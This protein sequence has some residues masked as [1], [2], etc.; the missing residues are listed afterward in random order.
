MSVSERV[1]RTSVAIS[2]KDYVKINLVRSSKLKLKLAL[3]RMI[4]YVADAYKLYQNYLKAASEKSLLTVPENKIK[5]MTT[6]RMSNF[7]TTVG[8]PRSRELTDEIVNDPKVTDTYQAAAAFLFKFL[9]AHQNEIASVVNIGSG[10]DNTLQYLSSKFRDIQFY[11]NDLMEDLEDI[12]RNYLQNYKPKQNWKFIRGYQLDLIKKGELSGDL[13]FFK[14]TSVA[15]IP[16]EFD[17][18]LSAL[19][20]S[21]KYV[22]FSESWE[23]PAKSLNIFKIIKPE[24]VDPKS[25]SLGGGGYYYYNYFSL[26]QKHGFEVIVSNMVAIGGR[27]WIHLV[28]RNKRTASLSP[29]RDSYQDIRRL[30]GASAD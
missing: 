7:A 21:A 22:C 29:S 14:G 25:P 10:L 3:G 17:E 2:F 24:D 20:G 1:S 23:Q 13:V 8:T 5:E 11:S 16:N 27:Y 18:L 6:P 26:L 12:H 15:L 4:A 30:H 28:A 9:S 19:S